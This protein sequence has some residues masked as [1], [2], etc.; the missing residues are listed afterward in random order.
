MPLQ[1]C[2]NFVIKMSLICPFFLVCYCL[3][4]FVNTVWNKWQVQVRCIQAHWYHSLGGVWEKGRREG[5][6]GNFK[7]QYALRTC[8]GAGTTNPLSILILWHISDL[9]LGRYNFRIS[10][11][12]VNHVVN[13]V[14]WLA[15]KPRPYHRQVPAEV[16]SNSSNKILQTWPEPFSQ[17]YTI[18]VLI[19]RFYT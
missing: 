11:K 4:P 5:E 9:A 19:T 17:G 3:L 16:V 6:G 15:R 18:T 2:H 13:T 10:H 7:W 1:K 14:Q 8:G 12:F